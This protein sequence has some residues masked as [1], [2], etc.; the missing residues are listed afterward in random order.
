MKL[1]AALLTLTLATAAHKPPPPQTSRST[2]PPRPLRPP[3]PPAPHR[4]HHPAAAASQ[5]ITINPAKT[6][7]TIDGFGFALTGGSA[8]L[9]MHMDPAKRAALLHELFTRTGDGIG[10]SYLRLT[11]GSSDMNANV[12]SY[13]DLAPEQTD[14]PTWLTSPS[15]PTKPTSSPS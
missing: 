5:T 2:S 14:V 15:I 7:Q 1:A 3:R 6:Y 4:L 12:F 8:Q 13:D 10:V 9:L 11:I